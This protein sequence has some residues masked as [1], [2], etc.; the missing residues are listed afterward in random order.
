VIKKFKVGVVQLKQDKSGVTV[1]LGSP[2]S[3]NEKFRYS[4]ELTVK[5]HLGNV[6]A[7]A[8]NGYLKVEDPRKR[9][10]KDGEG[11]SED[12]LA[13]IPAWIKNELMLVVDDGK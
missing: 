13:K 9:V 8:E 10:K 7:K 11:L 6:V 4:V 12:E 5:D 2:D 1:K 3:K